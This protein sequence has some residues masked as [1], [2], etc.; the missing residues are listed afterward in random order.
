MCMCW[1]PYL[2]LGIYVLA[3]R[4]VQETKQSDGKEQLGYRVFC[5]MIHHL[6]AKTTLNLVVGN[7]LQCF[8]IGISLS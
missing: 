7:D 6:L 4:Y 8:F 1:Q 2:N 5:L 3:N